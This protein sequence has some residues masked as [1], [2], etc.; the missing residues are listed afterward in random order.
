MRLAV[1]AVC[2]RLAAIRSEAAAMAPHYEV[3]YSLE[4]TIREMVAQTLQAEEGEN[5]WDSARIPPQI[6][7]DAEKPLRR[8]PAVRVWSPC[9]GC[10]TLMTSAP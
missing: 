6:K 7:N 4:T 8:F 10:S 3:F 9:P 5:W 1:A 2:I